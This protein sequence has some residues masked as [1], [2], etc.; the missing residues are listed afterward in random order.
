[1]RSLALVFVLVASFAACSTSQEEDDAAASSA[2]A[3]ESPGFVGCRP[4]AGECRSSCPDGRYRY[5]LPDARCPGIADMPQD[6]GACICGESAEP[7]PEAPP[8]TFI[9]CRPSAGECMNSCPTRQGS[10]VDDW[11]ACPEAGDPLHVRGGC[12]C[13]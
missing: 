10:Y 1:M 3:T 7:P 4:S 6:R 11:P 8:G 5:V 2:A 12:F 13:R 9:G